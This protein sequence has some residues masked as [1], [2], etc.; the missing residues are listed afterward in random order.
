MTKKI[1]RSSEFST[2][3]VVHFGVKF[4][5]KVVQ[6]FFGQMCSDEF[7]LK[8]AL[9]L[10]C[11]VSLTSEKDRATNERICKR[12]KQM[13]FLPGNTPSKLALVGQAEERLSL[14]QVQFH[15]CIP[16]ASSHSATAL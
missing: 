2:D 6:K 4:L 3:K 11:M 16:T 9:R 7:F 8:H 14:H 10:P 13:G 5:K 12:L 15:P 1:K